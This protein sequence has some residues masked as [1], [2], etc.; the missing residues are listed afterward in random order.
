MRIYLNN[1]RIEDY[2]YCTYCNKTLKICPRRFS[3]LFRHCETQHG[4]SRVQSEP[5]PKRAHQSL[6]QL[7]NLR[8]L[9]IKKQLLDHSSTDEICS[10]VKKDTNQVSGRND[11]GM[12]PI[13][14]CEES[15]AVTAE[16]QKI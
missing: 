7:R 4:P 1:K 9:Q 15:E 3:N 12:P 10:P 13:E 8:E 11:E 6:A 2:V 14:A 16:P 5:F